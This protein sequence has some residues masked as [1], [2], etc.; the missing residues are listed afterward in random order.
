MS[1]HKTAGQRSRK[2]YS[3]DSS[4][5]S[6]KP[7]SKS[8]AFLVSGLLTQF[9]V[10]QAFFVEESYFTDEEWTSMI[11][12]FLAADSFSDPTFFPV[13]ASSTRFLTA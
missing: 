4:R 1:G 9:K 7:H 8:A 6:G 10:C 13:S 11:N 12:G 2:A 5:T 3:S